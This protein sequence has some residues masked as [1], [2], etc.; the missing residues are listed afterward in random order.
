MYICMHICA[1][2][3]TQTLIDTDRQ[4]DRHIDR[5][6]QTDRQRHM[7]TPVNHTLK[8]N[9][10]SKQKQLYLN[11]YYKAILTNNK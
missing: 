9:R 10:D 3:N 11:I 8:K 2:T 7:H 5:Q 6:T 4:T 1:H